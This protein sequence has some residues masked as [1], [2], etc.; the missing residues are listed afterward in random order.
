M[1]CAACHKA[2]ANLLCTGSDFANSKVRDAVGGNESSQLLQDPAYAD[3]LEVS[4]ART[5]VGGWD[6][7]GNG[8]CN[9]Q[10]LA[11]IRVG[12]G[13]VVVTTVI[14]RPATLCD[15]CDSKVH[16]AIAFAPAR[17]LVV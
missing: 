4:F 8:E 2:R 11:P 6:G 16:L 10:L 3:A 15:L 1:L 13:T 9:A 7:L 12:G 17:L 14:V 5:S